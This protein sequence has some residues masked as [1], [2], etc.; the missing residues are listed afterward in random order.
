MSDVGSRMAL[1]PELSLCVWVESLRQG[2]LRLVAGGRALGFEP[3]WFIPSS[4]SASSSQ[5]A[6]IPRGSGIPVPPYCNASWPGF[7]SVEKVWWTFFWFE[8]NRR[9]IDSEPW[10]FASDCGDGKYSYF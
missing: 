10:F 1:V 9:G 7:N 3:P 5:A 6:S 4:S 8:S 2:T